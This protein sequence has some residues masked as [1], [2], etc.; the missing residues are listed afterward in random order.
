[1]NAVP[2]VYCCKLGQSGQQLQQQV[3]NLGFTAL[4]TPLQQITPLPATAPSIQPDIIIFT[5]K[6]AVEQG[7]R[8]LPSTA[9]EHA[10]V[11]AIGPATQQLLAENGV[12]ALIASSSPDSSNKSNVN[13]DSESL[14]T[15]IKQQ[16]S[17]KVKCKKILIVKGK[18]GRDLLKTE[19]EQAHYQVSELVCYQRLEISDKEKQTLITQLQQSPPNWLLVSNGESLTLASK[20]IKQARI[21]LEPVSLIIPSSRLRKIALKLHFKS[22]F[23]SAGPMNDAIITI[24]KQQAC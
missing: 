6:N 14:L 15:F 18:A 11:Y 5:S 10:K 20:L 22:V 21:P 9:L 12:S 17:D 16:R 23:I 19:L 7:L 8:L 24:L 13:S 3:A 2:T 4:W 1:M